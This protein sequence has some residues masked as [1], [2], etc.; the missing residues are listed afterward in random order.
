V[1]IIAIGFLRIDLEIITDFSPRCKRNYSKNAK[2]S[3]N[4]QKYPQK[5]KNMGS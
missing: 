4:L 1:V 2:K 5:T 3:K